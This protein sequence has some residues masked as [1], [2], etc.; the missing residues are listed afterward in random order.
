MIRCFV[1]SLLLAAAG[2]SSG[3]TAHLDSL[4]GKADPA[5]FDT[6]SSSAAARAAWE[7]VQP[8]FAARCVVCHACYDAPC[9]LKLSSYDGITRG[10]TTEQVYALRLLETAPTRLHVD[11]L[12][13]RQ[14]RERGFHPVLNERASSTQANHAASVM[15]RLLDLKRRHAPESGILPADR[16]D[17]S[18][19]RAQQCATIE[20]VDELEKD[21]PE[22]G[23]PFGM[24]QL[25]E[26][27][28]RTLVGWVEAGAPYA[29][30]PALPDAQL[31]HVG[32]WEAFLNGDSL[33]EKLMSRYIFEHWYLAHLYFDDLAPGEYF[34]LVRSSTP[35]GTPIRIIATRRPYD[36]PGAGRI[37]YRL[38]RVEDTLVV[39]THMPYA[40]DAARMKWLR[41]LFLDP[42]YQVTSLPSY[43]PDVAS[44]PFVAFRELPIR[45]RYRLM[46]EEAQFT[47]M[48]FIKGP[49]CR[50]QV[51]L[52]VIDDLFWVV[53]VNP[54]AEQLE[55]GA[56]DLAKVLDRVVLPAEDADSLPLLKWKK[57]SRSETSYLQGKTDFLNAHFGP[58]H[59]PTLGLLWD[60]DGKNHNAA[61]T[62]FRHFDSATVV[63][64][65]LGQPQTAWVV[66]YS[67]LERIHYLLVAGYDV[68][69]NVGHQVTTRMYMDFLR[70]E[71]ESN[72]LALLPLASRDAVRDHWYRGAS[73]DVKQYLQGEKAFFAHET[74]ITY[75]AGDPL[76]QLYSMMQKKLAPVLDHRYDLP[77]R[78]LPRTERASLARLGSLHGEGTSILPEVTFLTVVVAGG[79]E[80]HYTLLH[81]NAYS[82]ISQMFSGEKNRLPAED[83]VTVVE[84]FLGAY[85]NAFQ[86]VDAADLPAFADA[87][88]ALHDESGYA[89]LMARFGI[90]RTDS[91]FW[92][93]SD[94]LIAAY[95]R[96]APIEAG[97]FDYGRYENR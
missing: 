89:A 13:N 35:P 76:P 28:Y 3:V 62:V 20:Q 33:K 38:R 51:A 61:L 95:R 39:K 79:Q 60:G 34:D 72:F 1:F 49:V 45:S 46:L 56:D 47:I 24:P 10:G 25:S 68:Y 97:L 17:F 64:G 66:G 8:V 50:G 88:A 9:Q 85:P 22:L 93:V 87:V 71:G 86:V 41:G 59:S 73:D 91:R 23:M 80:H 15:C 31:R 44:N 14:W 16:Y 18:L 83:T 63:Q 36:D 19:D 37:Y 65:L 90:R 70:M 6:G 81:N 43:E 67:L 52:N 2:C 57:Y 48:N 7:K 42:D 54:E 12:S 21:L 77:I 40:L 5:R 11:A 69:G 96:S 92:P 29:P 26:A 75:H 84:G 30:P 27:E 82:N 32:E 94:A 55:L 78:G 4:Y 58:R 53:F 74:G